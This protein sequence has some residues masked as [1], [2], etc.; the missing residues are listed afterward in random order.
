MY[1]L[2]RDQFLEGLQDRMLRR[3]LRTLVLVDPELSFARVKT[4]AILRIKAD[5]GGVSPSCFGTSHIPTAVP[6][7][8]KQFRQELKAEMAEELKSQMA[9]LAKGVVGEL[10]AEIQ[11]MTSQQPRLHAPRDGQNTWQCQPLPPYPPLTCQSAPPVVGQSQYGHR[12]P[13]SHYRRPSQGTINP[14][15]PSGSMFQYDEQGRPICKRWQ[16][17]GH[18]QRFCPRQ[19]N[20]SYTVMNQTQE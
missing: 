12:S 18:I 20:Q 13:S 3:E 9:A 8:L 5:E 16:P 6:L 10:R 11:N 19:R 14:S 1:R 4:E 2:M 17:P 15:P 7:D